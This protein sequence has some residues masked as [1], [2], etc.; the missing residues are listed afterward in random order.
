MG[1]MNNDIL[2]ELQGIT[3]GYGAER[4]VLENCS[5]TLR[6]GDRVALTGANGAGKSTLLEIMI[7]LHRPESGIIRAF[8]KVCV[9][10][11]DFV[12]VRRRA[13]LLFE[14]PDDQLFWDWPGMRNG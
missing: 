13:G 4:R 1:A 3:A 11:A 14:D 12:E 7:G 10:E 9:T 5:L 6:A 8:G 2:F